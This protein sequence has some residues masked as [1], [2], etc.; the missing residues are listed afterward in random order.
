MRPYLKFDYNDEESEK[1]PVIFSDPINVLETKDISV[2][3]FIFDQVEKA[4]NEGYYIAGYVSYEAAPVFDPA[5]RVH[6]NPVMPLV[7]FGIFEAPSETNGQNRPVGTYHISDWSLDTSYQD[8]QKGIAQIKKAIETGE[9][10]QA[11]YTVRLNASFTGDGKAFYE[12]LKMNQ[13][14][15]YCAFLDLGKYQILSASPELFFRV[16]EQKIMTKPMKGT[17]RRGRSAQED[18]SYKEGLKNSEKEQA[19]NVMIVDLLRN[20]LGR[21]A[22]TGTIHVPRLFEVETYPTVHQMT[23]TIEAELKDCTTVFE[24]FHS[25]FPCGS[26]T[27]APKIRT[28]EKIAELEQSPRGVYCGAIGYIPPNR[29]ATFSVPIRTVIVDTEKEM[30]TYG[31]GGG[32]TWDST[33]KGEYEE[34]LTKAKLLT[35]KRSDFALLETLKFENKQYA[36]ESYHL[37]RLKESADYFTIPIDL[38]ETKKRL[39]HFAKKN[40]IGAYKV[41][42]LLD[43]SGNT[44]VEKVPISPIVEPVTCYLASEAIDE[45][46]PFLYHK[47][48]HRLIYEKHQNTAPTNAFSVLLWN[49]QNQLTEFTTGNLVVQIDGRLYTPPVSCGLLAGT[50]RQALLDEG[51]IEERIVNKDKLESCEA[52]WFINGVR[53]WLRVHMIY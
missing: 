28:M 32:V 43:R 49:Q 42:L 7:W 39:T 23:S 20:D 30:A 15:D 35:E 24:W 37:N 46:D 4:L 27:G 14:A 51:T 40:P 31:T 45:Q 19:E 11:N 13:Q 25:L 8:Y 48:T 41:R 50:Y 38:Q 5:Y 17:A 9:S 6:S 22:K 36:L 34:L 26:I 12:Q 44:T 53:G 18:R 10:Y 3:P 52:I 16:N 47:T 21:I 1:K 2:V 29:K 33:A